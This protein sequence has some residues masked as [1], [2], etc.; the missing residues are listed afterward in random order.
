MVYIDNPINAKAIKRVLE[1]IMGHSPQMAEDGQKCLD[2]LKAMENTR[3][4]DLIFMGNGNS[5][6]IFD[7]G[8][9]IKCRCRYACYGWLDGYIKDRCNV[10]TST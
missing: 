4:P 8:I 3:L 1:R 7:H 6:P 5:L 2:Q 10:P 9:D